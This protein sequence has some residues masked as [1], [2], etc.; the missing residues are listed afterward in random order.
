MKN[1]STLTLPT[2]TITLMCITL[3]ASAQNAEQAGVQQGFLKNE[4][5]IVSQDGVVNG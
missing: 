5:R 3:A 2:L 4:G 1:L